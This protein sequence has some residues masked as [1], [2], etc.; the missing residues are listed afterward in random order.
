M[1][2]PPSSDVTAL[3]IKNNKL[4]YAGLYG[5][6][7]LAYKTEQFNFHLDNT[8]GMSAVRAPNLMFA[9]FC[10]VAPHL[11]STAKKQNQNKNTH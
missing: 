3:F 8:Q 11:A 5:L 10:C 1:H 9:D 4:H 2:G 7:G 6:R